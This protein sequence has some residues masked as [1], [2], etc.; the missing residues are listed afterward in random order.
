MLPQFP[1]FRY[2]ELDTNV[3]LF[4]HAIIKTIISRNVQDSS[5]ISEYFVSRNLIKVQIL[6]FN[7][8]YK[9]PL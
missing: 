9:L 7:S 2:L 5:I 6:I 4:D 1:D 8:F 3:F